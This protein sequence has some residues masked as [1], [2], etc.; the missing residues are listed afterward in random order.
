MT[1]FSIDVDWRFGE[2][3]D[4]ILGQTAADLGIKVGEDCLTQNVDAW[5]GKIRDHAFVSVYPLAMWLASSWWR[6]HHEVLP[7]RS[8]MTPPQDWHLSHEMAAANCGYVWPLMVFTSDRTFMNI[9][10][11]PF[12]AGGL[13]HSIRYLNSLPAIAGVRMDEFSESCGAFIDKVV[14]KLEAEGMGGSELAQLWSLILADMDDKAERRNRRIEAQ[15][16]FDPEECPDALLE[17]LIIIEDD[18]GVDMLAELAAVGHW[19]DGNCA[20]SIRELFNA[21]GIEARPELPRLPDRGT[22]AEPWR[23]A[24]EDARFLRKS[25]DAGG[26][27]VGDAKLAELLGMRRNSI[28]DGAHSNRLSAT[29]VGRIDDRHVKVTARKRHPVARRFEMARIVGGYADVM[30]RD[31]SSWLA[32]TDAAT[33]SQKYQRAFAAEF[34]CPIE[35]LM[36]MLDGD[37]SESAIEDAASEFAVSERTVE[38][39]LVNERLIPHWA[40]QYGS[41]N[42]L[43]A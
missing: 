22:A 5:T 41:S 3:A 42:S 6:I 40:A 9:W 32:A 37:M 31:G 8:R 4:P 7:A 1:S 17:D 19:Q 26:G 15:F 2:E 18:L 34:L 12:P 16:G 28:G 38:A 27:A 39:Q 24:K 29:I 43:A 23:Q 33:A 11:E 36:E 30:V 25:I 21:P 14:D 35:S 10:T 20:E 13:G